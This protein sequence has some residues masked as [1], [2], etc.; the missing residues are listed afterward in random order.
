MTNFEEEKKKS[1]EYISEEVNFIG[2]LTITPKTRFDFSLH[3]LGV[4]SPLFAYSWIDNSYYLLS[5]VHGHLGFEF[6]NHETHS[7]IFNDIVCRDLTSHTC[8]I[9]NILLDHYKNVSVTGIGAIKYIN[10]YIHKATPN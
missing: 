5:R 1:T 8:I 3:I 10:V 6:L 4:T 2:F 7:A 9:P